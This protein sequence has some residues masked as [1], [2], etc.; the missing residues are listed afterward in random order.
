M[1]G[2]QTPHL[3][4]RARAAIGW[5]FGLTLLAAT[6]LASAA[7]DKVVV[8]AAASLKTVLDSV[9]AAYGAGPGALPTISYAGT[10]TIA[11]QVAQGAPADIVVTADERWM[12]YLQERTLVRE[13]IQS[14]FLGNR[15]VVIAPTG[16][17]PLQ[18]DLSDLPSRLGDDGRLALADTESVPAGRYARAALEELGLWTTVA[19]RTVESDNVRSA[20]AFVS[21]G[22]APAGIVYA[23]D[24]AAEPKVAVVAVI[25]A[26]NHPLIRYAVAMTPGADPGAETFY[27]FLATSE[28]KD[29]FTAHGFVV[30]EVGN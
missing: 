2:P 13:P 7:E 1:I 25:P 24:A 18:P 10:P 4:L 16:T 19:G 11:R 9:A 15:L 12:A 30:P 28:A 8:F 27:D 29:I 5:V 22:E 14:A 21:R 26:E 23:T 17:S 20:L 3:R 6:S